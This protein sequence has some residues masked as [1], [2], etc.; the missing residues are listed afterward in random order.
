MILPALLFSAILSLSCAIQTPNQHLG[1]NMAGNRTMDIFIDVFYD[2][3]CSDCVENSPVLA[4]L[5]TQA[6]LK[7]RVGVAINI[8]PL[9]YHHNSFFAAW[10]GE[11][12]KHTNPEQF[13]PYMYYIFSHYDDFISK[14][15]G[16][17][18][19]EVQHR[20]ASY[21]ETAT[22]INPQVILNGYQNRDLDLSARL[23][24][25]YACSRGVTGTPTFIVNDVIV[26]EASGFDLKQWNAYLYNLLA[27]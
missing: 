27:S 24:W 6:F 25:K 9:P 22:G 23:A 3:L 21:V 20:Y 4:Q 26:P 2:N 13:I 18:E 16:L 11:T 15:V 7:G 12:I 10:A 17:T 8:F 1:Y 14:A 19:P 5:V